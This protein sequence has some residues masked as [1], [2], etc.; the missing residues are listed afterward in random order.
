MGSLLGVQFTGSPTSLL[1]GSGSRH[2]CKQR[3]QLN[4]ILTVLLLT[5]T[6]IYCACCLGSKS[7]S[8]ADEMTKFSFSATCFF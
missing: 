8:Y 2:F 1:P 3:N 7:F 6:N 5:A 4:H